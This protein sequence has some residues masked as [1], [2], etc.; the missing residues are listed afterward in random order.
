MGADLA[1]RARARATWC[2]AATPP[3][4]SR[5]VAFESDDYQTVQGLVAAG[6]GVALIPELA[7]SVVREDIAIRALSP[8][9]PVRQVIAATPAG[10]RLV[11]AAPAM[12]GVLE[13][14][15]RDYETQ[16]GRPAD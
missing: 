9:P 14:V 3:A 8:A 10:A 11:P 12:L 5:N 16:R 1:A 6:V 15:A 7:L 2:A 13:Q 4:S